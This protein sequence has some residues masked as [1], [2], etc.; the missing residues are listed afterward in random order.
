MASSVVWALGAVAAAFTGLFTLNAGSELESPLSRGA[1]VYY[2]GS[3]GFSNATTR[4][5][6]AIRPEFEVVV[7]VSTEEDVQHVVSWP[8]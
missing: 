6:A 1:K 8:E 7:E 5:S 3:A 4:W 2:P